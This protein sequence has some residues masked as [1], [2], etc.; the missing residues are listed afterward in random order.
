MMEHQENRDRAGGEALRPPAGRLFD[1]AAAISAVAVFCC[2]IIGTADVISTWAFHTALLGAVELTQMLMVVTIFMGLAAAIWNEENITVDLFRGWFSPPIRRVGDVVALIVST[3]VYGLVAYS[4]IF[5]ALRSFKASE[6]A[7][8]PVAFPIFPARVALTAGAW[9]A[10]VA[11]LLVIW[12][13][14]KHR[15]AK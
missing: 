13:A 8:G 6:F 14:L 10:A 9:L 15:D 7:N 3:I 2:A 4:G 1:G 11:A 5:A 12:R